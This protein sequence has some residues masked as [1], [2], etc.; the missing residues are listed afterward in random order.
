MGALVV[1][2]LVLVKVGQWVWAH[3]WILVVLGFLVLLLL[4]GW[5]Y[6]QVDQMCSARLAG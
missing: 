5:M 3:W 2:A 4:A 6:R 1:V